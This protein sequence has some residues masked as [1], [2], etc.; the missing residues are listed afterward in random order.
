MGGAN[1]LFLGRKESR[2]ETVND[3]NEISSAGL[4]VCSL[5][6]I[7]EIPGWRFQ[8]NRDTRTRAQLLPH[9]YNVIVIERCCIRF[10]TQILFS[11]SIYEYPPQGE[12]FIYGGNG[13]EM[14]M[15]KKACLD[16]SLGTQPHDGS[17]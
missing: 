6:C 2:V 13:F 15:Y 14:G 16:G 1:L 17:R 10:F 12:G 7:F 11:R 5:H 9:T 3:A 4:T 8:E